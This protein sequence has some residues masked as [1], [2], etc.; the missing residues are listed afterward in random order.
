[1]GSD[2]ALDEFGVLE[3]T[4]GF[5]G[6]ATGGPRGPNGIPG[7]AEPSW[8][9][10]G[11]SCGDFVGPSWGNFHKDLEALRASGKVLGR[12]RVQ[13]G[14]ELER[15]ERPRRGLHLVL[16]FFFFED[17]AAENIEHF[18]GELGAFRE[19]FGPLFSLLG[20][21]GAVLGRH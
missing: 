3:A 13:L 14:A 8:T 15:P 10:M 6:T 18:F 4:M 5:L 12:F 7:G 2:G 11:R 9:V 20:R 21:L 1:M 19:G 16:G 17:R